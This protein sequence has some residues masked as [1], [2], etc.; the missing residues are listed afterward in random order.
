MHQQGLFVS[1]SLVL[2][3]IIQFISLEAADIQALMWRSMCTHIQWFG[4]SCKQAS[5]QAS[6]TVV[7]MF[8]TRDHPSR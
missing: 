1:L 2:P 8:V 3:I 4:I 6:S 7:R 5:N